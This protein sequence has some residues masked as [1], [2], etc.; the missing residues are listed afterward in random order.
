[1]K[2]AYQINTAKNLNKS[3]DSLHSVSEYLESKRKR[4]RLAELFKQVMAMG[5]AYPQRIHSMTNNIP[6]QL[7]RKVSNTCP[8]CVNSEDMKGYIKLAIRDLT[9]YNK[10]LVAWLG[11]SIEREEP[12]SIHELRPTK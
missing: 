5:G 12:K 1:M 6:V 2:T 11:D 10:H 9:T 7:Y 3:L 8:A 4:G